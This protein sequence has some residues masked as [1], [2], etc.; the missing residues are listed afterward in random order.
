MV[1]TGTWSL[2]FPALRHAD[3]L[4]SESLVAIEKQFSTMEP[5]G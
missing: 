3:T 1:V 5:V 4:T 2:F